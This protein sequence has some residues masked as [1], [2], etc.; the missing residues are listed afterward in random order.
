MN[1]EQST[2]TPDDFDNV[3]S[4]RDTPLYRLRIHEE[5]QKLNKDM[6]KRQELQDQM[7]RDALREHRLGRIQRLGLHVVRSEK[8]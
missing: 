3:H 8:E 7:A 1:M 4:I 5:L 2:P 6:K